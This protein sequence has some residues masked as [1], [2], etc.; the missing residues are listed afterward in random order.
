MTRLHGKLARILGLSVLTLAIGCAPSRSA[1]IA[2]RPKSAPPPARRGRVVHA[3]RDFL[4]YWDSLP[5]EERKAASRSEKSAEAYLQGGDGYVREYFAARGGGKEAIALGDF[6][7]LPA[8][9]FE[10]TRAALSDAAVQDR[11]AR[12]ADDLARRLARVGT[13]SDTTVIVLLAGDY[14]N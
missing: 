14:L 13:P 6:L 5:A 12:D 9:L 4:R 7:A 3:W 10:A 11:L 2:E 8:P 1:G